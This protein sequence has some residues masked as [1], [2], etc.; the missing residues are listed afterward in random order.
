MEKTK[1][2]NKIKLIFF[3]EKF[4]TIKIDNPKNNDKN[5]GISTRAK[6]IKL[7]KASSCVKDIVIQ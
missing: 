2:K 3:S 4:P 7:L 5:K 6:G 1:E